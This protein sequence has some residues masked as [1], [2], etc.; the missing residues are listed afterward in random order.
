V[1]CSGYT[2]APQEIVDTLARVCCSVLK[3]VTCVT[4]DAVC[5]SVLQCVVCCSVL[6]WVAVHTWITPQEIVGALACVRCSVLQC[7]ALCR[8][9]VQRVAVCS[10]V[11]CVAVRCSAL[12]CVAVD[13]WISPQKIVGAL[14][15]VH[16]KRGMQREDQRW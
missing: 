6:Q 4:C 2:C 3:C 15:C 14:A 10:S 16:S 11:L 12:Q 9:V 13:T 8:S 5:C 1:R 7:L